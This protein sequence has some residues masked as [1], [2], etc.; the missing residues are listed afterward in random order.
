M[1]RLEHRQP[2]PRCGGNIRLMPNIAEAPELRCLSCGH[3]PPPPTPPP[4][5]AA[6]A[7]IAAR[8]EARR[9]KVAELYQ[10]GVRPLAIA[11]QLGMA[12]S[13]VYSDLARRGLSPG[14]Q[15][16]PTK[17][18]KRI[19]AM[20]L[21]GMGHTQI[22]RTLGL[23]APTVRRYTQRAGIPSE[24]T[25]MVSAKREAFRLYHALRPLGWSYDRIAARAGVSRATLH[26]WVHD[27]GLQQGDARQTRH[28]PPQ[29]TTA[30]HRA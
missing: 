19:I 17:T 12:S 23:S 29:A 10:Q 20:R 25:K 9:V 4:N 13:L 5:A 6:L 7:A 18:R 8:C 16:I 30:R 26:R 21:A 28:R 27:A 1:A 15:R 22:E 14:M 2:C 11:E 24:A 3:E